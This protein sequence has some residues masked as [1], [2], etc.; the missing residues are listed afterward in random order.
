MEK[1][2]KAFPVLVLHEDNLHDDERGNACKDHAHR[3]G[4]IGIAASVSW[5]LR[6]SLYGQNGIDEQYQT[7]GA[8]HDQL[9]VTRT[10]DNLAVAEARKRYVFLQLLSLNASGL[11]CC[12]EAVRSLCRVQRKEAEG[13]K[14]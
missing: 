3:A 12:L 6:L 7:D 4:N 8:A 2:L 11:W 10:L 13:G 5:H 1:T 14:G 9:L